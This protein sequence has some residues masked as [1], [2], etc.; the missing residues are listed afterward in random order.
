MVMSTN[1]KRSDR[2]A[3]AVRQ[4]RAASLRV[5][6]LE[7]RALMSAADPV[8]T[9]YSLAGSSH[10]NQVAQLAKHSQAP[11]GTGMVTKAPRFY[12]AYT[13]P[14]LAELNAVKASGV[15]SANGTFTFTGTNRGRITTAPAVYVWG[16][17]RGGN[18]ADGPF[19]NRPNV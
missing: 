7:G 1:R 15:L 18:L 8:A 16:I 2:R 12:E 19:Q 11:R 14:K 5:E 4:G 17:D 6:P 10:S 13:G 3:V 9:L